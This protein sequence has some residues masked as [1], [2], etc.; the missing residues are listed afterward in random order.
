MGKVKQ[1]DLFEKGTETMDG[2]DYDSFADKFRHKKTTDDCYTPESV[3]TCMVDY[4]KSKCDIS[5]KTI[6]RPFYPGGDYEHANYNENA[7][8]IDNPP[9]SI[10]SKIVKFY[11]DNNVHFFLFAPHLT[12]FS[13]LSIRDCTC[14]I[15][16]NDIIYTNGAKVKTSFVTNM[17]GHGHIY[18][19]Y[20]LLQRLKDVNDIQEKGVQRYAYPEEVLTVSRITSCLNKGVEVDIPQSMTEHIRT[21]DSQ[22]KN[23]RSLFGSGFLLS[24]SATRYMM[25]KE[26]EAKKLA[27]DKLTSRTT[28]WELSDREREITERLDYNPKQI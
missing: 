22:K 3:Y 6:M 19:D 23:G 24:R 1:I 28:T 12:L 17:F 14:I 4:V 26:D 13:S 20:K 9:F 18:S 25:S 27:M 8:V 21:L 7:V 15:Y 10:F 5:E 2:G 16:G 11:K